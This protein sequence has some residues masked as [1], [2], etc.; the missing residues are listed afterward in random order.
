MAIVPTSRT[1]NIPKKTDRKHVCLTSMTFVHK[2]TITVLMTIGMSEVMSYIFKICSS[3]I[4]IIRFLQ[5]TKTK[6]T[7]VVPLYCGTRN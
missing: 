3:C 1:A 7:T 6:K 2:L 5:E 4:E